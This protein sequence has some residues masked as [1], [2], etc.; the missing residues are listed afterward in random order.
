MRAVDQWARMEVDLGAD[1]DDAHL[2]FTPE[3]STADAAAVLAP[4]PVGAVAVLAQLV[5]GGH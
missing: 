5:D 3:G 1:W 4:L 2:A